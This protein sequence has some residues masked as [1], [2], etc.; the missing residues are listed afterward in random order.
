MEPILNNLTLRKSPKGS[1]C[2]RA[3]V[4]CGNLLPKV[5]IIAL[6]ASWVGDCFV[7]LFLAKNTLGGAG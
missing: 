7:T 2:E 5:N 4:E 3:V 1:R 6:V